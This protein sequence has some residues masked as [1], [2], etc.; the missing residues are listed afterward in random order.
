MLLPCTSSSGNSSRQRTAGP[1]RCT[2]TATFFH[3]ATPAAIRIASA[4]RWLR[5]GSLVTMKRVS[6]IGSIETDE[7][8]GRRDE[9][10][11]DGEAC[12]CS[13][14]R[15]RDLPLLCAIGTRKQIES[16]RFEILQTGIC[17]A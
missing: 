9:I 5:R 15:Y 1:R 2:W 4:G 10:A 6:T 8:I 7:T 13:V 17:H 16:A 11:H 14:F 12:E 3:A